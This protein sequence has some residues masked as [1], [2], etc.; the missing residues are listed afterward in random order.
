[1][2]S[3][4]RFRNSPPIS[5]L[6]LSLLREALRIYQFSSFSFESKGRGLLADIFGTFHVVNS[7]DEEIDTTHTPLK[8]DVS[9][10][11][12]SMPNDELPAHD[13]HTISKLRP[14]DEQTRI[15]RTPKTPIQIGEDP[16]YYDRDLK[17]RSQS[18]TKNA[19]DLI[20]QEPSE[21]MINLTGEVIDDLT[22]PSG[23][24]TK[25]PSSDRRQKSS[26]G[27][28]TYISMVHEAIVSLKERSGSSIPAITKCMLSKYD[29]LSTMPSQQLSRLILVAVKTGIRAGRF[30]K[31]KCSYKVNSAW[32][33]KEKLDAQKKERDKKRNK[34]LDGKV[35]TDL[36][37][38][39]IDGTKEL[40]D[41]ELNLTL[42]DEERAELKRQV[43]SLSSRAIPFHDFR[44]STTFL[45]RRK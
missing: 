29:S 33:K 24:K 39:I 13:T 34:S 30:V 26:G 31:V 23:S 15:R 16:Y 38:S 6:T 5:L 3:I 9:D 40:E 8:L 17:S 11:V 7:M 45:I 18:S 35:K 25:T 41:L 22:T 20:E 2:I 36:N 27:K 14:N 43:R 4:T 19:I 28:G 1:L 42:T 37:I 10:A 21:S 44:I 32:T 12:A